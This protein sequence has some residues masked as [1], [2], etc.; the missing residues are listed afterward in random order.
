MNK[1]AASY[2]PVAYHVYI[3]KHNIAAAAA[4]LSRPTCV[5]WVTATYGIISYGEVGESRLSTRWY[6]R[7]SGVV[8]S[9][10]KT[11]LIDQGTR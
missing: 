5:G 3:L 8:Y 11:Y 2:S 4:H 10:V 6:L 1:H 9:G 7:P